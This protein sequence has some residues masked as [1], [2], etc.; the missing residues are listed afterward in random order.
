MGNVPTQMRCPEEIRWL[1]QRNT[2][3]GGTGVVR[4]VK[5]EELDANEGISAVAACKRFLAF[6]GSL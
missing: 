6:Q 1:I 3:F 5:V 2:C 4:R